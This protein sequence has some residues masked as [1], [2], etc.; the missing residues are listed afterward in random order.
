MRHMTRTLITVAG[1]AVLAG[2]G[3][4]A[5]GATGTPNSSPSSPAKTPIQTAALG[6]LV[7]EANVGD[8]GKS[9][10]FDTEGNDDPATGN[11]D[12]KDVACVLTSLNVPDYVVT[13]MDATRALDGMQEDTWDSYTA[14]W[15]YHPDDGMNLTVFV[16]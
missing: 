11:D 15:T 12:I 2:C 5:T 3:S 4:G 9:I 10:K 14:R 13:H 1:V 7:A 6:C 16:K 8:A